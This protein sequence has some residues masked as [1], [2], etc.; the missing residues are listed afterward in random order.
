MAFAATVWAEGR[1]PDRFTEAD[2]PTF[3][4]IY[5]DGAIAHSF[6]LQ[7][8]YHQYPRVNW[9]FAFAFAAVLLSLLV[10]SRRPWI[11]AG[12]VGFGALSTLS[13]LFSLNMRGGE[14][15]FFASSVMA[16]ALCLASI[17]PLD[18]SARSA[19]VTV[20]ALSL[21]GCATVRGVATFE[22]RMTPFFALSWPVW[23][24]EVGRW[25]HDSTYRPRIH[26]Q[27]GGASWVVDLGPSTS[28]R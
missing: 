17:R 12:I 10:G 4:S 18:A 1:P 23:R 16:Y 24:V 2:L 3:L 19:A 11:R 6:L 26:P 25:R 28:S 7:D 21:I 13:L 14:R 20:L 5:V 9:L 15:Y 8:F 27:W 22:R